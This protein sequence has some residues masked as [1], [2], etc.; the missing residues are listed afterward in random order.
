MFLTNNDATISNLMIYS[1]GI[2]IYKISIS[3]FNNFNYTFVTYFQDN[4]DKFLKNKSKHYYIDCSYKPYGNAKECIYIKTNS[5][6]KI[7]LENKNGKICF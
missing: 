5:K 1:K 6:D 2:Y 4:W 7:V 3:Q